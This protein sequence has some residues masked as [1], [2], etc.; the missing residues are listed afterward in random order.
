MKWLVVV[1]AGQ[2]E[3]LVSGAAAAGREGLPKNMLLFR[4]LLVTHIQ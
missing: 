4:H 3:T 1:A 2:V